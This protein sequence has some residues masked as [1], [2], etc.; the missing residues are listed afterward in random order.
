MKIGIIT[1]HY[2]KNF[3][4]FLQVYA[5]QE[6]LK[7]AFPNSETFI[8]NYIVSK[9][10]IINIGGYFRIS[11]KNERP[12]SY[13]EKIKLIS[14]FKN[15]ERKYLN[16]T[17]R[18]YSIEEINNQNFDCII[19]GS[20]EVWHYESD[21][22]DPVK[23]SLGL[24]AKSIISYAP[25]SGSIN[26]SH[27]IPDFVREG[28]SNFS[29]ISVRDELSEKLVEKV[30]GFKAVRVLDPTLMYKFPIIE[31]AFTKR[32]KKENYFLMYHC[33][34]MPKELIEK[35]KSYCK[36]ENLKI[37]GAGEYAAYYSDITVNMSPFQWVEM[38]R[39]AK[40][41]L[42]GTFHGAVFSI[43]MNK[44]FLMYL[45]PNN[46][47]RSTKV[48]SLLKQFD[49]AERIIEE[50]NYFKIEKLFNSKIN[51]EKVNGIRK[52]MENNS[53]QFIRNAIGMIN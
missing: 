20:D 21:A 50:R 39:N 7:S 49:I 30:L 8:I 36:R 22:I 6:Y 46:K 26:L 25:S 16:L 23:F 1:H 53:E 9:H 38:F 45:T 3:G 18:V 51:Y 11:L 33:V 14:S 2:I 17:K 32:I 42:S 43:I 28:L 15:A 35:I 41:I 12:R 24:K 44:N 34:G 37:Y 31:D 10:K 40:F 27:P 29:F 52:I 5:L 4:A 47:S 19:I 13:F 48:R